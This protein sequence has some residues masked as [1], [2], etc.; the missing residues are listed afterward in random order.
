MAWTGNA[1]GISDK[2]HS[3]FSENIRTIRTSVLL[4]DID[5][6]SKTV[7]ITSSIPG[8]GKSMLAINLALALGQMGKTLL[9]DGDMRKPVIARV[10]ELQ[11]HPG[12]THFIAGTHQLQDSIHYFEEDKIYIM[13]GGQI[14][15]NP[16]E[17]ISSNRFEK[18]LDAL[19]KAFTYIAIDSAP[20]VPVSDPVVLSR[21]VNATI[22]IVK[23]HVTPYQLALS[24]IKKLQ[25]VNANILGVVLN[26]VNPVKR[27]GRYG[28]G[29]Y[30]YYT[31]YGYHKS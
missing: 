4:N 7:L 27:P 26:Q 25:Q 21:L 24:G 23:A 1:C 3:G 8:E 30:D 17:L 29:H 31:Y 11:K 10:F 20:T 18:G 5:A 22:Y 2:K 6:P 9:I 13:P 14:P 15:S 28:Y 12:L 19:K 16:L